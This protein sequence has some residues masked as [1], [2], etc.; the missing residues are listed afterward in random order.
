M[1]NVIQLALQGE[2]SISLHFRLI[3][4]TGMVK[5]KMERSIEDATVRRRWRS[6]KIAF[7]ESLHNFCT[8]LF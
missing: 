5:E 2:R 8:N 6:F 3:M 1:V 4:W 7:S